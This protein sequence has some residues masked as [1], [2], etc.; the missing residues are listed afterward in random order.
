MERINEHEETITDLIWQTE[1]AWKSLIHYS[2]A[3]SGITELADVKDS[4]YEILSSWIH[5][6]EA[7]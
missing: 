1:E 2:I 3:S 6:L 4:L 5:A 7:H